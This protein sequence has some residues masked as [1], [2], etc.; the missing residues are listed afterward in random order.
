MGLKKISTRQLIIFFCIYSFSIKFLTLPQLLSR[1]AGND[2]WISALV[3]TIIELLLIWLVLNVLVKGR[4]SD[5]Y[6]DLRNKLTG[7]GAKSIIL[8]MFL[9]LGLQLLILM[10]TS[11]TLTNEN[12]FASINKHL[13]ILPLLVFGVLFCFVP[14]RAIFRSGEVFYI[15]IIVALALSVLPVIPQMRPAEVTPI[16][17]NGF[18]P[19]LNTVYRNLIYFESVAF[20]LI[21]SGD[22]KLDKDFKKKFMSI[23][24]L[25]GIFFVF[26]VFMF[27]SLFG[28]L[29]EYKSI[30]IANLAIYT[31]FL[32]QG[33]RL[34]W[35]L[36][37]IW[38]LLLLL[39]FGVTF[40]ASFAC[41]R[42]IFNLKHRAGYIGF[43]IAISLYFIFLFVL[44]TKTRLDN[45]II[46]VAPVIAAIFILIPLISFLC[47]ILAR[48]KK[49]TS[50]KE[51]ENV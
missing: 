31:K 2:A 5:I 4:D 40:F 33:G 39:R 35:V 45:F 15:L 8:L 29:A 34:D 6:S 42:Y 9:L 21:F 28:P 37:C 24:A 41:I 14:A 23:A 17:A 36:I 13:F 18:G 16:L 20:L 49:K 3:G 11:F 10:W 19:I 43:G 47:A 27:Q 38:L 32:T 44:N 48:S 51:V 46:T 22:I 26:F 7:V 50:R 25:I 30:A 1:G 12:L